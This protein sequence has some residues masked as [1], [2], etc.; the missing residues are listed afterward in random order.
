[1]FIQVEETFD[2]SAFFGASGCLKCLR[3]DELMLLI[4]GVVKD[5]MAGLQSQ[6]DQQNHKILMVSRLIIDASFTSKQNQCHDLN[7]LHAVVV[8]VLTYKGANKWVGETFW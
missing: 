4:G 2:E 3:K 8:P 6:I 7:C 5:Q 1:M